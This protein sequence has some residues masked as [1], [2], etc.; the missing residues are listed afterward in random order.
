M[1]TPAKLDRII[2]GTRYRSSQRINP[3]PVGRSQYAHGVRDVAIWICRETVVLERD[4]QWDDGHG[5]CTGAIYAVLNPRN[6]EGRDHIQALADR[7]HGYVDGDID[8]E[9][10]LLAIAR[11]HAPAEDASATA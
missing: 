7:W 3:Q 6:T 1:T 10:I 2:D 11:R 4:S 8:P 9:E 5:R